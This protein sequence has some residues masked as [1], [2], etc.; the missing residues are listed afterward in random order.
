MHVNIH[1]KA[2]SWGQRTI[3][4]MSHHLI[5]ATGRFSMTNFISCLW[6]QVYNKCMMGLQV[7]G[8]TLGSSAQQACE[9]SG[10]WGVVTDH[11]Y[12]TKAKE[13]VHTGCIAQ[14]LI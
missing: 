9:Y 8:T 7:H 5:F 12:Y 13:V 2:A 11:L 3:L 14:N 4:V 10:I 6:Q 1:P